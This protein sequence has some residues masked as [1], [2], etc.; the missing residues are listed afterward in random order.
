MKAKGDCHYRC[1]C[2][3]KF[4][5]GM[6]DCTVDSDVGTCNFTLLL[7]ILHFCGLVHVRSYVSPDMDCDLFMA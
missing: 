1:N 3:K 4:L 7:G 6:C 5:F 2:D